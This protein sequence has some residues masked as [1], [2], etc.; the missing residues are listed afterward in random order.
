MSVIM[1][2]WMMGDPKQLEE[3]AS[4]NHEE[5]QSILKSA[6]GH[7]LIAHRFYGTDDGQ[8]MVI[9]EWPDPQSFQTFF[10]ENRERIEPLMRAAGAQGEPGINFWRKLETKDEYGWGV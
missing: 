2:L 4:A 3:H 1:T 9:D 10:E 7:G 5:M 8:I 6:E